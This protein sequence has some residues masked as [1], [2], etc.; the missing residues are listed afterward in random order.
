M[1]YLTDKDEIIETI[2]RK[3]S[4]VR[5]LYVE[6]ERAHLAHKA[7]ELAKMHG[8]QFKIIPQ[9]A[10]RNK[11]KVKG[12][13]FFLEVE[14]KTYVEPEVFLEQIRKRKDPLIFAFDGIYDPQNFGNILRSAGC[15]NLDGIILPRDRT[16]GI[17]DKVMEISKGGYERVDLVRVVNL[18]RYL[19][20]LKRLGIVIF[21]LDERGEK[22][23]YEENLKDAVCIVLGREDGL[24]ALTRKKCDSLLR[25]PTSEKFPSLNLA[26]SFAI[27]LYEAIRQRKLSPI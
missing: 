24:R 14:P 6:R 8:I 13:H 19:E 9:V 5:R 18:P 10:F 21:G 1:S 26:T 12:V 15:F 3:P 27:A 2:E 17:T 4:S 25:I 22:A 7:I 16:C 23:V 20:D 11:L